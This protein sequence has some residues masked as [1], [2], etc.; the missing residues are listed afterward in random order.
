MS[1]KKQTHLKE[2][3]CWVRINSVCNQACLFCLDEDS[4]NGTHRLFADIQKDLFAGRKRGIHRAVVSGGEAT[5]HPRF[6][7]VIRYAKKAGYTHIQVITNGRMFSYKKYLDRAVR[8]GLTE[9]TFSVHGHTAQVHDALVGVR[10]AFVQTMEALLNTKQYPG[11][12]VSIDICINKKNIAHLSHI[13]AKFIRLGFY[14]FDL[15]YVVPYGAAWKNKDAM[16]L[17]E[18]KK[19]MRHLQRA[20]RFAKDPRVHL[21]TN[22][23]PSFYLEGYE[24]LIQDPQKMRDEIV[25]RESEMR[26]FFSRGTI[27]CRGE[28]CNACYLKK[29]CEDVRLL[30][31]I[32]VLY[33]RP[34]PACLSAAS[35]APEA[36][37]Y[38][39]SAKKTAGSFADFF[40]AYRLHEKSMRC[41]RCIKN[42]KCAGAPI[43]MIMEKGFKILRPVRRAARRK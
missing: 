40:I 25:A 33:A 2:Y 22:R 35:T 18:N 6:I 10:G 28:R 29:F 36:A 19:T 16:L 37:S 27:S 26:K 43:R 17:K 24:S 14:E 32:K 3:K 31:K 34:L 4:K 41:A 9:V 42:K 38:A 1:I 7:D 13:L 15:L 8:A 21:W 30:R 12:I 39:F 11:L 23:M 20:F 5:T